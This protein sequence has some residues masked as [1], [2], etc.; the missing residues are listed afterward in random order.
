MFFSGKI[1]SNLD[2]RT[3]ATPSIM[4]TGCSRIFDGEG[5]N[6]QVRDW[7]GKKMK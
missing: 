2:R 7:R 1:K 6:K 5:N 4:Y 3:I